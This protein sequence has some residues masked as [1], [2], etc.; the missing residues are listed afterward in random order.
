MNK[1]RYACARL[2][3]AIGIAL[4]GAALTPAAMAASPAVRIGGADIGGT[5]TGPNGPE[6]GVWV[7]AETK[8]LPTGF[9]KMVVTDDQ[10]R[11]VI[12]ELPKANYQVW[13]RG[14]GLVDSAKVESKPGK[15]LAL[16]ATPAPNE[17]AAA[18][19]YPGVYWYSLLKIPPASDFP[20]TGEKGNGIP[21]VMKTQAYWIDSIKNSCQ[22]CHALGSAWI[23]H[24][25]PPSLG[26]F[27]SSLAG[28]ARRT[29]S[30]QAMINMALTLG[31]IGPEKGL[32]LFADWTDRIAAGELP[33]AKPE[34]PQGKERNVV[35]T[36]W[37]WS[38]PKYY[39]HDAVSTDK[40]KPTVN[41][42]GLIYG[43]P[44]ESTDNVP[45]LD[46]VH[47]KAGFVT[48]PFE[49]N[50]PSSKTLAMQPSPNWGED[51]IWDGHSSIHNPILDEKGRLWLTAR[52][53]PDDNPAWC[54]TGS[55]LPSA[56]LAPQNGSARQLSMY[57]PK[58]KKWANIN[59]CFT[60][61]H[62]YFAADA[63]NTLWTS[64]GSPQS[65][66]V[67]WLNTKMY[68][69]THD[70]QKSQGW[71]PLIIDTNGNGKRDEYTEA[72]QPMDPNKDR[73]IMAAFYGVQPSPVDD[74]IW[75][76]SMDVGF[77]RMDQPGYI[78]RLIPGKDPTHTSMTEVYLPPDGIFGA[79]G[80]DLTS[81]G[82][83][84]SVF[85]SGH[86][87]SFDRRKCKGPLNGPTAATGKQCPEGWTM[88]KFPGPQFKGVSDQGA[89]DHAYYIWVDRFN[90][91]GLGKDVPIAELNG[92]ESLLAVVDGKFVNLHVPYPMGFFTKNVDGRIDN[93]NT[94]W[95]G[96]AVWTSSGT[97]TVFHN[98]GGT[99][100]TP[101]VY[102][103]QVRP[104]PLA[105]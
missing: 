54:K 69:A 80:I 66:V 15:Q 11:F 3:A 42:N 82:V 49:P 67:G 13:V 40:R 2:A 19:Y 61:Q 97:R 23:R 7:I 90:T 59:T 84:W 30:G 36:S 27:D 41:A 48:H 38:T 26:H 25:T 4:A 79:R 43:S 8:D 29:Q 75:G 21:A 68:L 37:N 14:Y 1:N 60:T 44:E 81:D 98:E 89:A 58:T 33:F 105:H 32:S 57:D 9:A 10:G 45:W 85:S 83:V 74:S 100:N 35:I 76:Q 65:G 5:V 73:R 31:R 39:L 28:W 87:G 92:G 102:K 34:R 104:D 6:A 96:R 91:L 24:G 99:K 16:S 62:L 20:G 18:E 12:P 72:N 94:G 93:P 95:K 55:S 63:N 88:Y 47:N 64:A 77:S 78:L 22:S 70:E 53:R 46:P 52:F 50:T 86:M 101:K 51:P 17:K 103:F 56:Q 71:T